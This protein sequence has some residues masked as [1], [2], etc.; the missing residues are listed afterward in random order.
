MDNNENVELIGEDEVVTLYDDDNNP[1]DFYEVAVVEYE[2]EFYA[3]LEPVNPMEG[4]DEDEVIIFKLIEQEDGT[5][6][7]QPVESEEVLNAVFDE[8]LRT[9][10][11]EHG[12]DC[13]CGCDECGEGCAAGGEKPSK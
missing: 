10:A 9:A 5:D 2:E 3:L 11:D 4:I 7:F 8:Y 12:H 13:G 6:L 1:V